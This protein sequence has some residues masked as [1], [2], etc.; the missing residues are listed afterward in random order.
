MTRGDREQLTRISI[1]IWTQ[2]QLLVKPFESLLVIRLYLG[3][4]IMHLRHKYRSRGMDEQRVSYI[5]PTGQVRAGG[6]AGPRRVD[7]SQ[8]VWE[9]RKDRNWQATQSYRR[10]NLAS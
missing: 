10:G 7:L 9:E 1:K 4:E 3:A 5:Q 2:D 8:R 6:R